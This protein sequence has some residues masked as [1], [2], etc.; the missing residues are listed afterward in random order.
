MRKLIM[1]LVLLVAVAG[2]DVVSGTLHWSA[3]NDV[4]SAME[5]GGVWDGRVKI[6]D[7]ND[8][9]TYAV[10]FPNQYF[11]L[12][13]NGDAERILI[14]F[15]AVG[16]V[17]STTSWHSDFVVCLFEDD[18]VFM[19]TADCRT[20]VSMINQGYTDSYVINFVANN[21]FLGDRSECAY[22]FNF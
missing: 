22:V 19:F 11:D 17:S 4:D 2:A 13:T 5:A 9:L 16:L 18:T 10:E 21:I 6:V 15:M 14:T 20:V 1:I 3:A 12:D 8:V 7:Y